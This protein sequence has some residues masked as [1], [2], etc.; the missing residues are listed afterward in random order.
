MYL[1]KNLWGH[2]TRECVLWC[3]KYRQMLIQENTGYALIKQCLR[4]FILAQ[5]WR[6][7]VISI[8]ASTRKV[9]MEKVQ[10]KPGRWSVC[11]T[12]SLQPIDVHYFI[13]S[14]FCYFQ[15]DDR[16][17]VSTQ[18]SGPSQGAQPWDYGELDTTAHQ[19]HQL[20]TNNLRRQC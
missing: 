15:D 6:L 10:T 1:L 14:L 7:S 2:V 5:S 17:M 4:R 13:V 16:M 12:T 19:Q 8:L 11:L 20:V 9:L 18:Q 3:Y